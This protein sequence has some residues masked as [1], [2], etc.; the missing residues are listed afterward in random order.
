MLIC[1]RGIARLREVRGFSEKARDKAPPT[2]RLSQFAE[3]L[4]VHSLAP[5]CKDDY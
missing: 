5:K 2:P 3:L 4:F 1:N